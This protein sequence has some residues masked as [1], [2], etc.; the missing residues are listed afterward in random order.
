MRGGTLP[1]DAGSH[2]A[3]TKRI[4]AGRFLRTIHPPTFCATT[5]RGMNAPADGTAPG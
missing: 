5:Q 2:A 3:R 1:D 4:A